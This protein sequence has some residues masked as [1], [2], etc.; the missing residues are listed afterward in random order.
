MTSAGCRVLVLCLALVASSG[1]AQENLYGPAAPPDAAY[2]RV[3]HAA[4]AHDPFEATLGDLV[5]PTAAFTDATPYRLLEP[6]PAT[7]NA[8]DTEQA[9]QI[10]AGG[11]YT[12][13]LLPSGLVVFNDEPLVDV[14]RALLS[15]YNLSSRGPLDLKTV[16]GE[17]DVLLDVGAGQSNSIVINGAEVALGVF[18]GDELVAELE[19]QL[20]ERGVAHAVFVF[21]GPEGLIATYNRAE[22]QE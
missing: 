11:F 20:L 16:D 19:P 4:S 12:A 5:Y 22:L 6:G 14:S 8:A 15:F 10:E 13:V 21:D 3:V 9:L 17:T 1:L 7:L 2:F 18:Q